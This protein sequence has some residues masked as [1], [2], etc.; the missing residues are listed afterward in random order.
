MQRRLLIDDRFFDG[1]LNARPR[2]A[3]EI[4]ALRQQFT[5]STPSP[6]PEPE[7]LPDSEVERLKAEIALLRAN[8]ER[9]EER[10]HELPDEV[11]SY[12]FV[13]NAG[14]SAITTAGQQADSIEIGA[15]FIKARIDEQRFSSKNILLEKDILHGGIFG[16]ERWER[17]AEVLFST[18]AASNE[19]SPMSTFLEQSRDRAIALSFEPLSTLHAF[20]WE[21]AW[22]NQQGDNRPL[23]AR[24]D[25]P[26]FR[27]VA[28]RVV[29][30]A[31]P[32]RILAAV[33]CPRSAPERGLSPVALH[34]E[35][36]I[37]RESFQRYPPE[38][39]TILPRDPDASPDGA[40][41][42][43]LRAELEA[44]DG[45]RYTILHLV[46]HGFYPGQLG[47]FALLMQRASAHAGRGRDV[48]LGDEFATVLPGNDKLRLVVLANCMSSATKDGS[49]LHSMARRLALKCS[50]VVGMLGQLEKSA[51]EMFTG[52]FYDALA[53]SGDVARSLARA[54]ARLFDERDEQNLGDSWSIPVL[55]VG[56]TRTDLF[57]RLPNYQPPDR[58]LDVTQNNAALDQ[59]LKD[60]PLAALRGQFSS[61]KEAQILQ[62]VTDR[63]RNIPAPDPGDV[64]PQKYG[65]ITAALQ[66]PVSLSAEDIE[67]AAAPLIFPQ[68]V[69]RQLA[70]VL[71]AGKHVVLTGPPGTGK[72]TLAK[73]VCAL[74]ADRKMSMGTLS[75]TATADW[76]TFETVGGYLPRAGD[77]ALMFRSGVFLRAIANGEWL[78]I[79]E[80]NRTE[81]DKAVGE[82][83]TVLSDQEVI[84]PY[85][86][87]GQVLHVQPPDDPD[88]LN[89][90]KAHP[91]RE[92]TFTVHPN[93]R[94]IAT[95]NIY[96]RASLFSM[97]LAF[98]RRF[99]FIEVPVLA[100]ADNRTLLTGWLDTADAGIIETFLQIGD[101]LQG[102][103]PLGPALFKDMCAFLNNS[104]GTGTVAEA[105]LLYVTPQLDGLDAFSIRQVYRSLNASLGAPLV[106]KRIEQMY[107]YIQDWTE[108][109]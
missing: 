17:L 4:K 53:E 98:M 14:S 71:N 94:M 39:V 10:I 104:G 8:A 59:F 62:E 40:T 74:V 109:T 99:A 15:G 5:T 76:T 83:F 25:Q 22:P 33:I 52:V 29:E 61:P 80:L 31:K 20:R 72:T 51:H 105:V 48:V 6:Q 49:A 60:G 68:E 58:S 77:G 93:W 103:R 54:R 56:A 78:F 108:D 86:V 24:V 7:P 34:A 79:D 3:D 97:S 50:A 38:Q 45:G 82:I 30:D 91:H 46:G 75:C 18:E 16:E 23:A 1:L 64:P 65:V 26:W 67:A 100:K 12:Y 70:A 55:Y 106:Q 89:A 43:A 73:R 102:A 96:D 88:D 32:P 92:Y 63:I 27:S 42:E 2:R 85:T 37:L 44:E 57:T 11:R 13:V 41:F 19:A 69:F 90:W 87:G 101:D 66:T 95:M 81:I 84:L 9:Q 36:E 28:P 35:V 47:K 107:P 21:A